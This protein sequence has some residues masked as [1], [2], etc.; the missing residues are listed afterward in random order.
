ME[1]HNISVF[2]VCHRWYTTPESA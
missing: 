1:R 2:L